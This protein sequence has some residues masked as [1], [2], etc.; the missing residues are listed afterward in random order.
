MVVSAFRPLQQPFLRFIWRL[1][2]H[3]VVRAAFGWEADVGQTHAPA[4]SLLR[5][6]DDGH[7]NLLQSKTE[8]EQSIGAPQGPSNH[9]RVATGNNNLDVSCQGIGRYLYEI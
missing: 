5:R 2:S 3:L 1:G 8:H 9:E 4:Y 7:G 6:V